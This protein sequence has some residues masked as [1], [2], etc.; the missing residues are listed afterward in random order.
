MSDEAG[1]SSQRSATCAADFRCLSKDYW[2]ALY[3]SFAKSNRAIKAKAV[4]GVEAP[5]TDEQRMQA[6]AEAVVNKRV[7]AL[8]VAATIGQQQVQTVR[9]GLSLKA[10]VQV[11]KEDIIREATTRMIRLHEQEE[12]WALDLAL[13]ALGG[14]ESAS[15]PS[16]EAAAKCREILIERRRLVQRRIGEE[17][18][19]RNAEFDKDTA[20][21]G[22]S[23]KQV[24]PPM[25]SAE[26]SMPENP[27]TSAIATEGSVA[28]MPR[29]G[30]D[31]PQLLSASYW[32]ELTGLGVS[33]NQR[34]AEKAMS[35]PLWSG[36]G[37]LP[38]H[39][40]K[41]RWASE[42]GQSGWA[43]SGVLGAE[44]ATAAEKLHHA[45]V[46]LREGGW[47]PVFMFMTDEA[48][49]LA[50]HVQD[51]VNALLDPVVEGDW[52]WQ[53]EPSFA[54]FLLDAGHDN[55]TGKRLGNS[56]PLPHRDH[57]YSA[58]FDSS[59]SPKLVSVWVPLT[60]VEVD[61]GC[62]YVVPREFDPTFD[63][64]DAYEHMQLVSE[65]TWKVNTELST[66]LSGEAAKRVTATTVCGFPL[67]GSRPLPCCRG[68]FLAWNTNVI[69][70]GSFCHST[71]TAP[72]R[73]S[74]AFV[75]RRCRR[76]SSE[77]AVVEASQIFDPEAEPLDLRGTSFCCSLSTVRRR[78][79]YVLAALRYFEH[80]YD[81][82]HVR[83]RI[84]QA[85]KTQES[86]CAR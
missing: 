3:A 37:K 71:A 72:P 45:A 52:Y 57:S 68:S 14:E 2:I 62:M 28:S 84:M 44:F 42:L 53:L 21:K 18:R 67:A 10:R 63:K 23:A 35:A 7:P 50:A 46:R 31:P 8:A 29:S 83:E 60:D 56:F 11:L 47:P 16:A 58:S 9:D 4:A 74:A 30:T 79:M 85:L 38:S 76:S 51:A 70:W 78:L 86:P 1:A 26:Q 48:W 82:A 20:V 66:E 64:D 77:G 43:S 13:A 49:Q 73:C 80:W 41:R 81:A 59:G 12:F 22:K 33:T 36:G 32:S 65:A 55:G 40:D 27:P 24:T 69:H 25:V 75:F 17:S 54:A 5:L 39:M 34:D 6:A 61:S 15:P 19:V